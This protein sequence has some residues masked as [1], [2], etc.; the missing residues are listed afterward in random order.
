[1]SAVVPVRLIKGSDDVL[2]GEAFSKVLDEAVGDADRTLVVD[3]IDLDRTTLGAAIDAAQTPPF[4]TDFRVVVVRRFGRYSKQDEVAPLVAYLEDPLPTTALILVWEKTN[5]T[6]AVEG[7]EPFTKTPKIPPSLTKAVTG[8]GGV[9]IET[10][11]ATRSMDSWVADQFRAAGLDLEPRA[12]KL[13]AETIGEDGGAVVGIIERVKGAFG[14]GA[15]IRA[16]EIADYVG[17]AGGVPP[18]DLTDAIDKGDAATSIELLQRMMGAGGRHALA[19]MATL[20]THYLRMLRLDGADVRGE[21][22]AAALLGMK[23]SSYP[24]KKAMT[25]ARKLGSAK[26]RRAV[27]LLA[28]ADLDL[29]GKQA[30]PDELVMEV[31]VARLARLSR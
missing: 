20:Q 7:A 23:G 11:A 24:A 6:A 12:A 25:Q 5:L 29:R 1:M 8:C 4:L 26:V 18:W 16:D 2:R 13:V 31:L 21:K 17:P 30:W 22:D 9:V 28:G 15:R 10:D 14:P 19:I 3:E 27:G